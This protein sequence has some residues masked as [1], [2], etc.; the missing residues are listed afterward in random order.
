MTG[1]YL[2]KTHPESRMAGNYIDSNLLMMIDD[3]D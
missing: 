1:L 2:S 3:D